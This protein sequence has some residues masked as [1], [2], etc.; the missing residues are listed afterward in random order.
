MAMLRLTTLLL[1]VLL[2][3]AG[4]DRTD[5]YLRAGNWRPNGS[6][7]ANLRAMVAVPAD[8]V[9]AAP[10]GPAGSADG[11]L[12]AAA[13]NRLRH[14]QVRP[15]PDSGIAQIVPVAGA[16]PGQPA[17]APAAGTGN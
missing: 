2:V 3:L 8:L 1:A 14:D 6:N 4:C 10:A 12:A 15:L 7:A 17:A 13:V 5:P 11:D 16:S 9:T